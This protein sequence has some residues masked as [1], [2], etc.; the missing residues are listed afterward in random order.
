MAISN[1][2]LMTK[3]GIQTNVFELHIQ[4]VDQQQ[5][6]RSTTVYSAGYSMYVQ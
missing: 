6:T 1:F 4:Y 3:I 5:H 2:L